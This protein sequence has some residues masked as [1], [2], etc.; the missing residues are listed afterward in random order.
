MVTLRRFVLRLV[1]FLR[2]GRAESELS[3]EIAA[4][5]R[6]LEDEFIR[7]GMSPREARDAAR[8][9]FGGVEQ[10]KERQ[11]DVRSFG[12]IDTW[13]LDLKLGARMLAR[14][15][16]VSLVGGFALAF[17]IAVGAAGFEAVRQLLAPSLPLESGDEVIGVSTRDIVAR[18]S[19]MRVAYDLREL[20]TQW[21]LVRDLGAFR[22]SE[23]TLLVEGRGAEPVQ[24]AD[25]SASGFRLARVAPRLGRT[26]VDADERAGAADVVVIGEAL[27][28]RS[29]ASDP[30]IVG[31]ALQ[32]GGVRA[33]VVGVMPE[34]FTFPVAHDAWMPL[35][36]PAAVEPRQGPELHV[37]GRLASGV[38]RQQAQAALD[39]VMA[40]LA[41]AS[42]ET[43]GTLRAEA[44]PYAHSIVAADEIVLGGI[45]INA[46]L[47]LLLAL[48]CA[49]VSALVLVRAVSRRGEIVVRSAL[50]ATRWRI[51]MQL[52]AES[53]VL[54]AIAAAV[55]LA[56]AGAALDWWMAVFRAES[57]GRLPFWIHGS[58]SPLTVLYVAGLTV[59]GAVISGV[60]PALKVTGR[61]L[62]TQLRQAGSGARDLRLG[63]LWTAVVIVQVAV[64]VTFPAAA[65][66]ARRHVVG[67]QS[68]PTGFPSHEYL[69]ARLSAVYDDSVLVA[70]RLRE[71]ERRLLAQPAV[72][73]VAF[74][75]RMP[76]T[77][78]PERNIEIEPLDGAAPVATSRI[79][80][81]TVAPGFF[82]ALQAAALA[83]R[84]FSP[85]DAGAPLV[86]V[87]RSFVERVMESANPVG[88]R[89][90]YA[91]APGRE[92]SRWFEIIGVVRDLGVIHDDPL[93]RAGVY[94][95]VRPENLAP[96]HI[97]IRVSGDPSA[98]TQTLLRVTADLEPALRLQDVQPL[99]DAGASLWME[100]NFA[101]KLLLGISAVAL[102]LSLAGVYSLTAFGVS[103][104]TPEI[105]IRVAL[106]ADHRQILAALF[107]RAFT[108]IAAGVGLGGLLVAALWHA[109]TPLEGVEL[110]AL[111]A[112]LAAM[113][114]LCLLACIVPARR[115]LAVDVTQALRADG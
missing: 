40:R 55:G 36:L 24:V 6:L 14:Y 81:A 73:A 98:F 2:P 29:F 74:A 21:D 12:S 84:T 18:T 1:S 54:G 5:L 66:L 111:G 94:H 87:N 63:G 76:R 78:H 101:W 44:V 97:A 33:T 32:F 34:G 90:R 49:N 11:R 52:F 23:R 60:L 30:A 41:A 56:A 100:M 96:P 45:A 77:T 107:G 58:L 108:Q 80:R 35:R 53:L 79:N 88:R 110:A 70:A 83:G 69:T 25:I 46:F 16:G 39:A 104:R 114:G 42:P 92:A 57:G 48:I 8:R 112:Y 43:H 15:P 51:V 26:L 31:R 99:D 47:V 72:R 85:A 64:T 4:H 115:A 82:E 89:L 67:L 19:E 27:W 50:G 91:A 20:Q 71:L 38:S 17:G 68:L 13:W 59:A 7:K 65:F 106:G 95:V 102:L 37:F 22:S 109:V 113:F 9:A 105:G 10:V 62:E 103:R 75:D 61:R 28:R 86:V 93:H 3:R